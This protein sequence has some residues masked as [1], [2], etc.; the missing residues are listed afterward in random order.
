[1]DS[2]RKSAAAWFEI[3][4][5]DLDRAQRFYET[6]LGCRMTKDDFGDAG[7]VMCVFPAERGGVS[8][9]LV[10]RAFQQ[11]SSSGTMV[12]LN[13]DG[14]L[15][16]TIARVPGAGGTILM[17]RTPVP[18]RFGAFACFRDSEGNHVGIHT[19]I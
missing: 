10:K 5:A 7:D 11:P 12:Y 14:E 13:C 19:S 8:G 18:G 3:P 1:M 16:G 17:K 15:D 6:I 4:C 9:A 2:Q